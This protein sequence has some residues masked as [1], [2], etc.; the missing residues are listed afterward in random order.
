MNDALQAIRESTGRIHNA[1]TAP[2]PG[3]KPGGE[4]AATAQSVREYADFAR[5]LNECRES[6]QDETQY[7]RSR[8]QAIQAL[9]RE[10]EEMSLP[11]CGWGSW[12]ANDEARRCRRVHAQVQALFQSFRSDFA[13]EFRRLEED[14]MRAA[15]RAGDFSV[16]L[17]GRTGAGK[18]TI[19]EAL[20]R[21]DGATIGR[22][23]SSTTK[24]CHEYTWRNLHVWDTPGID[25]G[26]DTNVDEDGVGDEERAALEKLETADI[27]V[28]VSRTG[29]VEPKERRMLARIV[30]SGRPYM[31]L[32]NVGADITKFRK[33][34]KQGIDR[35]ITVAAQRESI[36]DL[37][38]AFPEAGEHLVPV[39]AKACF[40]SRARGSEEAD[41]FYAKWGASRAELYGIS[42]FGEFRRKLTA[43]IC[44][45]GTAVRRQTIGR[46]FVEKTGGF[47]RTQR[48]AMEHHAENLRGIRSELAKAQSA[49]E[50]LRRRWTGDELEWKVDAEIRRQLDVDALAERCIEARYDKSEIQEEWARCLETALRNAQRE[51]GIAFGEDMGERLDNLK[52]ALSFN[53]AAFSRILDVED[54]AFDG[55]KAMKR[56]ARAAGAGAAALFVAVNW[57]NPGGWVAALGWVATGI[58]I[59]FSFLADLFRSKEGKIRKLREQFGEHLQGVRASFAAQVESQ[60]ESA[61]E[62]AQDGL[63]QAEAANVE[64]AA[65]LGGIIGVCRRAEGVVAEVGERMERHG[66]KARKGDAA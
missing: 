33:F 14:L 57:W 45:N 2:A 37:L 26:K 31:I 15:R 46:V 17:F 42:N 52:N 18:S 50:R 62:R 40:L 56:G 23:G 58:G 55:R 49:M 4:M 48:A 13:G 38:G 27:A 35:T 41:A 54:N 34:K 30:K 65:K 12:G 28:F 63:R 25:S 7:I 3:G 11:A 36:D 10:V 43:F 61:I 21:G 5:S 8:I 44:G 66:R 16:V 20:T 51:L 53:E 19:R 1:T 24:E 60:L 22:G 47:F 6:A 9:G 59:A 64:L 32:L 29:S 39:H